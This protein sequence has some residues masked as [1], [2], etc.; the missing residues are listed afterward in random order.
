LAQDSS[1]KDGD[2]IV[3]LSLFMPQDQKLREWISGLDISSM[4][5]LEALTELNQLKEYV[6]ANT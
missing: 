5:P 3:Q 6:G 2:D 4:T 1:K